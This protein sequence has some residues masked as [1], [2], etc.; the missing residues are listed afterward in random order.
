MVFY[1]HEPIFRFPLSDTLTLRYI[2]V[3]LR[4]G[5]L[6]T[7]EELS[8]AFKHSVA[9]QRR[10]ENQYQANGLEG[11]M[12]GKSSGRPSGI[13]RTLDG[14]LRTW[15][16]QGISNREMSHRLRVSDPAIHRALARLG[17]HRRKRRAAALLFVE[18]SG[19]GVSPDH[20]GR[21]SMEPEGPT[22][23]AK[24]ASNGAGE[25]AFSEA[26]EACV[27]KAGVGA[28]AEEIERAQRMSSKADGGRAP[29]RRATETKSGEWERGR[30]N[31]RKFRRDRRSCRSRDG[32]ALR[33]IFGERLEDVLASYE[34][35]G[36]TI[37]GDPDDRTG[38]RGLARAGLLEDA[39]PLFGDRPCL[40]QAGVLLAIPLLVESGLLDVFVRV[41]HS[42]APAF[43]GLRT[44]VVV[45]FLALLRIK[46]PEQIKEHNPQELG[47][48]VG[49]DRFPEVKT[50]H[51]KL[52]QLAAKKRPES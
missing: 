45:L 43:Y 36:F 14:V 4:L 17:L 52:D 13:P 44:T 38:D 46:R 24:E 12:S 25:L 21:N 11:L 26:A 28:P 40:R 16:E 10:W 8:Q 23:E 48:V 47:H 34:E 39:L 18:D 3:H 42:L 27:E 50:I 37:D 20:Q 35:Q 41:Y 2:A 49:L 15:F 30:E 33:P 5:S 7:Q 51:R 22:T 31:R 32:V 1:W 6:A 9:T 19:E 29:K